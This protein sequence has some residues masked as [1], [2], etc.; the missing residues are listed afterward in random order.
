MK[1]AVLLN[2]WR[3]NQSSFVCNAVLFFANLSCSFYFYFCLSSSF[4]FLISCL[5]LSICQC[6]LMTAGY[7]AHAHTIIIRSRSQHEE[8]DI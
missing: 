3:H 5:F 4:L 1:I 7:T 2:N 6:T 8:T